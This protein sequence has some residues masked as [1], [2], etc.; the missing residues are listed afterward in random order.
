MN[1]FVVEVTTENAQAVLIEESFKRP[2]LIDFWA[3]W[4]EPCKTLMPMLEKIAMEYQGD[5]L[6]AKV[7]ADDQQMIAAQFGVRSLPTVM[8]MKDGQPVDGFAGAQPEVQVR[9]MLAKYLPKPWEKTLAQAA[10]LIGEADW[11]GAYTL[12]KDAYAESNGQAN[13]AIAMAEC[14]I[15]LKRLDDAESLLAT[16]KMVDQDAEYHNAMAKLELART[17]GKAPELQALEIKYQTNPDDLDTAYLLA[18]QYS[19][20]GFHKDALELLYGLLRQDLNAKDGEVKKIFGDVL[21]VLGKGDP[22]AV[23]YQRKMY[24]LL[25]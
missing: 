17:A 8:V 19:Q 22:L 3:D 18:V 13:I 2:V 10:E 6:L 24:T 11:A 7:N 25:Y 15:E 14:L 20:E 5:L 16:I 1:E 4:C 9:E 21:A 12:L 23:E